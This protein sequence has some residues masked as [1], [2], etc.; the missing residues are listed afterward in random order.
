MKVL[1]AAALLIGCYNPAA[2]GPCEVSCTAT[3]PD[4]PSGLV[5]MNGLCRDATDPT[6]TAVTADAGPDAYEPIDAGPGCYGGGFF[7]PI[8]PLVVPNAQLSLGGNTLSTDGNLCTEVVP[9]SGIDLCVVIGQTI[10]VA[11][12]TRF[13]GSRPI[14]LLATTTIDV[15]GRVDVSSTR[16]M[17]PGAAA[18]RDCEAPGTGSSSS[19]MVSGGGGGGG[20][21]GSYGT[22]GGAGGSGANGLDGQGGVAAETRTA[23]PLGGCPGGGGGNAFNGAGGAFPADG[24]GAVILIAGERISVLGGIDAFGSGG[25]GA[26][27]AFAGGGGGGSGGLI[28]LDAPLLNGNGRLLAVGGGGGAGGNGV[29]GGPGGSEINVGSPNTSAA[30]G[31]AGSGGGSGGN[32]SLD[33]SGIAGMTPASFGGGGGGGGGGYIRIYGQNQ[34]SGPMHPPRTN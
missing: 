20:G 24:G 4:C 9:R 27:A 1:L 21:G 7:A 34:L 2:N 13:T 6:C 26:T 5:C 19:N 17:S 22:P 12:T 25:Y 31:T 3:S 15:T 10:S 23:T 16:S 33:G 14:V 30:G 11:Q 18:N 8:C 29:A 28:V 32:G